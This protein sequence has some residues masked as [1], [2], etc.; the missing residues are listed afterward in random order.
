M[1]QLSGNDV[2]WYHPCTKEHAQEGKD[3]KEVSVLK[4]STRDGVGV[5][6]CNEDIT[7]CP[8]NRHKQGNKKG[9]KNLILKLNK[10]KIAICTKLSSPKLE[11]VTRKSLFICK[12]NH[13]NKDEGLDTG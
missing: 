11:A 5:G 6:R 4:G 10:E 9:L 3:S 13:D 8:Y 2:T 7:C 1:K 12:A